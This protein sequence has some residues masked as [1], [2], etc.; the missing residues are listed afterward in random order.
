MTVLPVHSPY[1]IIELVLST[2]DGMAADDRDRDL[3]REE[4]GHLLTVCEELRL[5]LPSCVQCQCS[6]AAEGEAE[7]KAPASGEGEEK[8]FQVWTA[9]M[10]GPRTQTLITSP[11]T[12]SSLYY[13]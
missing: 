9:W 10:V 11:H 3:V 6:E 7:A 12:C 13:L 4:L 2:V 5:T 1:C 8:G